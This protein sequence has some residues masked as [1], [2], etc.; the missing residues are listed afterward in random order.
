[1]AKIPAGV[2]PRYPQ[3][4]VLFGAIGDLAERKLLPG[5][6]HLASVGFIPGCRIIGVS[7][8]DIDADGF[9]AAAR[10]ALDEFSARK[11][12]DAGWNTFV[13]CLDDV[14]LSAGAE[15]L[16]AAVDKAEL[17]FTGE[18]RRLHYL[19]MPPSAALSAVR[20]LGEARWSSARASSWKI[21]SAPTRKVP[22][23]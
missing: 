3:V 20:M 14:P 15:V 11:V 12:T 21:R 13:A 17:A 19:S 23:R 16:K 1:M 10:K 4:G 6:F 2:G 9:R 7:L 8:D 18:C 5:L 22:C